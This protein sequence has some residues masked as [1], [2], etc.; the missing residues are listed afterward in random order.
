MMLSGSSRAQV[1]VW[2]R[3]PRLSTVRRLPAEHTTGIDWR[4]ADGVKDRPVWASLP[5]SVPMIATARA[6]SEPSK[7]DLRVL[8]LP[9]PN[10][11]KGDE[12]IIPSGTTGTRTEY[13]RFPGFKL[14]SLSWAAAARRTQPRRVAIQLRSY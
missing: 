14:P 13:G 5:V 1:P 9:A 8:V 4:K 11:I 7:H 10:P 6:L 2:E 12:S 3:W